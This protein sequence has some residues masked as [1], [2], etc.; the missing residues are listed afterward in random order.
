MSVGGM[1]ISGSRKGEWIISSS[2]VYFEVIRKPLRF[3]EL[4]SIED[5]ELQY[6]PYYLRRIALF[7]K[8]LNIW[9]PDYAARSEAAM[10]E[11]AIENLLNSTVS[12]GLRTYG[13][14]PSKNPAA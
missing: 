4:D 6:R 9:V 12:R 3:G 2:D 5:D 11:W 1:K 7:G 14:V 8:W 10:D 13:V